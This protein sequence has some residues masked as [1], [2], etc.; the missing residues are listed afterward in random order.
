MHPSQHFTSRTLDKQ[1]MNSDS[2]LFMGGRCA[3]NVAGDVVVTQ[4][5]DALLHRVGPAAADAE[6]LC[7]ADE[8]NERLPEALPRLLEVVDGRACTYGV[9]MSI[10]ACAAHECMCALLKGAPGQGMLQ[11]SACTMH[12][13]AK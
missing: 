11:V 8:E 5:E 7:D 12:T 1:R 10:L 9:A 13:Q 6:G 2:K 4:C 3:R